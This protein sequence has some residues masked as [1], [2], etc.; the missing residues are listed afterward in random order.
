MNEHTNGQ[1]ERQK[2]YTPLHIYQEFNNNNNNNNNDNNNNYYNN[3]NDKCTAMLLQKLYSA[4]KIRN[5]TAV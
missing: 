1:T 4:F 3:N 5:K 2:L